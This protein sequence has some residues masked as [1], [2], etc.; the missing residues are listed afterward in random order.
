MSLKSVL[1]VCM[2]L[3]ATC[4]ASTIT[5]V[6]CTAVFPVPIPPNAPPE[7]SMHPLD[8]GVLCYVDRTHVFRS[9]PEGLIGGQYIKQS[10]NDKGAYG[11]V[12]S[13]TLA[14]ASEVFLLIDKRMVEENV[15]R[16][17]IS[18]LGFQD[19]GWEIGIDEGGNGITDNW[20]SVYH[21]ILPA[22]V[23]LFGDQA[24][25]Y[26][27]LGTNMYTII[28]P[29]FGVLQ[30][31]ERSYTSVHTLPVGSIYDGALPYR[32]RAHTLVQV[33]EFIGGAEFI[34]SMNNYKHA[35][36]Y[37][38]RLELSSNAIVYLLLDNRLGGS[39][40]L[41]PPDLEN[42]GLSWVFSMGFVDTG[43]DVG[44]EEGDMG[45][46][47]NWFS[48]YQSVFKKGYVTL[49][50]QNDGEQRNMYSVVA[51]PI[52][53]LEV[54]VPNGGELYTVGTTRTITWQSLGEIPNVRLEYSAD[55]GS[56]WHNIKTVANTGTT[57][58]TI[59]NTPSSECLIKI[60]DADSS[61]IYD[62]S[63]A[64]FTIQ[65]AYPVVTY[66]NGGE[67]YYTGTQR[68]IAWNNVGTFST[69]LIEY[70][71]DN[72]SNWTPVSP[73]NVGNT[74]SY[75]WTVP[76]EPSDQCLI[77]VSDAA[78]P[79]SYDGSNASFSII[80]SSPNLWLPDGGENILTGSTFD[81]RWATTG[82]IENITIEYSNDNGSSWQPV[83]PANVGNAGVYSWTVPYDVSDD[84]LMRV[85]D[86]DHPEIN[87][88]SESTFQ[89]VS[90]LPKILSPNGGERLMSGTTIPVQ[91]ETTGVISNI[92]VE[93]SLDAGATWTE[94]SPPNTGNTGR[95]DWVV[96][97]DM[98]E[99]CLMRV[100]DLS[101]LIVNAIS[102][103]VFKISPM[104]LR[105]PTAGQKI[106]VSSQFGIQWVTGDA[107]ADEMI[108][109]HYSVNDG[110]DWIELAT[111][112]NDGSYEWTVPVV[113]SN[114]Y[115]VCVV[116]GDDQS[117]SAISEGTFV[118]YRCREQIA[119]DLDGDCTVG[120]S[121]LAIMAENWMRRGKVHVREYLLDEDLAWTAEG[122]WEFGQPLG[123][124]GT[125]CGNP[126]PNSGYT[127][128]NVYGITLQGD[129]DTAVGGPY[130]LTTGPIDCSHF[131]NV[132]VSFMSWL[133]ID[134]SGYARCSFEVSANGT[135]WV[136]L[137]S[138][139]PEPITDDAWQN[140]EFVIDEFA[141]DNK[142]LYL[143]W[144]HQV[145]EVTHPYSGWNIDDVVIWSNP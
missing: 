118:V 80:A 62:I 94:V 48:I 93:Y 123:L 33:P 56:T 28:V 50:Q 24:K 44:I 105:Q 1:L 83:N 6:E 46:A 69:A 38:L 140:M 55:N 98:S 88:I 142:T 3:A 65:P 67:Q 82:V 116:V 137:W 84:C 5:S 2:A 136:A 51:V 30:G 77:R 43:F 73:P 121:D 106:L 85:S 143:R 15:L 104:Y 128:T 19:T 129:Y 59:P 75:K 64:P 81:V 7:I 90:S 103:N 10:N 97:Y 66:P 58:W 78:N 36:D 145:M 107:L 57:T 35:E 124:G 60:S 71:T 108:H 126:D 45:T 120:L 20:S 68:T 119:G 76:Y 114:Q 112:E 133:N 86:A 16:P 29:T 122:Q 96:P 13:V 87:D 14:T 26:G 21:S 113:E 101:H 17:W 49:R 134:E 9:V 130:Y 27:E 110:Q 72:G 18:D 63:D 61:E 91:W 31:V 37:M 47:H 40:P 141:D 25:T 135:D 32:D 4:T 11:F 89:I 127:G 42:T 132:H 111:T 8:N 109:I 52:E 22:G 99:E 102:Q 23:S 34:Q 131:G 138:N 41:N 117:F 100:S 95:Y 53:T 115:K 139:T 39:D 92:L 79:S 54:M 74:K 12:L 125:S 144:G 70:S